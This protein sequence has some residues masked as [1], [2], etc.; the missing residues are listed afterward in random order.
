MPPEFKPVEIESPKHILVILMA[1]YGDILAATP[2]LRA[3]KQHY[4]KACVTVLSHHER[5]RVLEGL[6]FIDRLIRT[7]K[8]RLK[9]LQYWPFPRYDLGVVFGNN[10][11][12]LRL[13]RKHCQFVVSEA[14]ADIS[15]SGLVDIQVSPSEMP[16]H[17]VTDRMRLVSAFGVKPAG[18]R[19]AYEVL[20]GEQQQAERW[21]KSNS[22]ENGSPLLGIQLS[23]FPTKSYR[24]WPL[25]H[26]YGLIE[27]VFSA[28]PNGRVVLLGG[29]ESV[30][31]A[32]DVVTHFHGDSR[33]LSAVACFSFRQ[34][35]ALI[36]M[37][38]LYVGPDTGPTHL[39]GA[40]ALPMVALYHHFPSRLRP[41]EHPSLIVIAHPD[42]ENGGEHD[43]SQIDVETVWQ[44]CK[45]LLESTARSTD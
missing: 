21:L 12:E 13:A 44:G 33:I 42:A 23:S 15:Q 37:L 18:M 45:A 35:A 9:W 16:L 27:Q 24:D 32:R 29:R 40:L 3:L 34:N 4:P 8:F 5:G 6:P 25:S 30:D 19:C 38:D 41:L 17:I 39:R 26:W 43:M 22:A 2:A 36:S 20:E 31:K 10:L 28:Y 14:V 11:Q 7:G 1:R